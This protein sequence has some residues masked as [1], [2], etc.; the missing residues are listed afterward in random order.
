[1][2]EVTREFFFNKIG[3]MDAI[4]SIPHDSKF[5]YRCDFKDRRTNNIIGYVQ[6]ILTFNENGGREYITKYHLKYE[7]I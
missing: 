2:K 6:D 4:V 7:N 5:P 3:N 1:M